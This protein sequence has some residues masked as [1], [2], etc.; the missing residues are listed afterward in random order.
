[1]RHAMGDG[2]EKPPK[3]LPVTGRLLADV[4]LA[5]ESLSIV[6]S[7]A[8]GEPPAWLGDDGGWRPRDILP[9]RN[10]LVHLPEFASQAGGYR[11][12]PT[13]RFFSPD[14]LSYDFDPDPPTPVNWLT[15]LGARPV[16]EGSQV[17]H[18]VWPG[19]WE[20]ITTL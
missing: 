7:H 3:P 12:D 6:E 13:P 16:T 19:D 5:L 17:R 4:V 20:N 18:Q 1:M 14:C 9:A 8:I 15:F 11:R 10:A 2:K